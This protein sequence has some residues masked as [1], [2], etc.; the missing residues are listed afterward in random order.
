M[1]WSESA[2]ISPRRLDHIATPLINESPT[3]IVLY[4]DSPDYPASQCNL[5]PQCHT[6]VWS[7]CRAPFPF[8]YG[9]AAAGIFCCADKIQ[10]EGDCPSTYCC[11]EPGAKLGCQS[12]V[13]CGSS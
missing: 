5:P 12:V 13:R 4:W 1:W 8:T 6:E 3:T 9:T 10:N 2:I 7:H 11:L